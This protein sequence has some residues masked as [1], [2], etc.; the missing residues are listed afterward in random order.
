PFV[1]VQYEKPHFS[2]KKILLII[3]LIQAVLALPSSL[4]PDLIGTLDLIFGSGM[5]V[6]GSM[7]C[8]L[9]LTWGLRKSEVIEGMFTTSNSNTFKRWT[10]F[11]IR[12]VIPIALVAVLLGYIYDSVA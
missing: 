7:L 1:S 5:Q 3:G 6:L 8:I 11:W 12:W 10:Y 9:G 2:Q 4:Y